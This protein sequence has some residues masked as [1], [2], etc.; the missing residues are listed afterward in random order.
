M[1]ALITYLFSD[2]KGY[3]DGRLEGWQA[4]ERLIKARLEERGY[5]WHSLLQ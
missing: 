4:C 1:K 5:D 3:W 2:V